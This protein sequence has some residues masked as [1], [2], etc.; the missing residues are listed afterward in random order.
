MNFFVTLKYLYFLGIP[1][2]FFHA[3]YYLEVEGALTCLIT[4]GSLAGAFTFYKIS[5]NE[6][7]KWKEKW[8]T[9]RQSKELK[10]ST[11]STPITSDRIANTPIAKIITFRDP[12]ICRKMS[13]YYVVMCRNTI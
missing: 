4:F 9:R 13:Q 3:C 1:W 12:Q 5:K 8:R 7:E 10:V 6:R 2:V 11:E